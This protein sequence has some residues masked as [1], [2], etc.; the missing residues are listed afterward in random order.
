MTHWFR[1]GRRRTPSSFL[2]FAILTERQASLDEQPKATVPTWTSGS[3]SLDFPTRRLTLYVLAN[4]L[5][6]LLD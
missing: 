3:T 2:D 5:H 4:F 1:R 6:T